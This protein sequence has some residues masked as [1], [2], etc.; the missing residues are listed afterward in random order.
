MLLAFRGTGS[1]AEDFSRSPPS[2]KSYLH[3][4]ELLLGIA[5]LLFFFLNLLLL[6]VLSFF[7]FDSLLLQ[8]TCQSESLRVSF[9]SA[10]PN[11]IILNF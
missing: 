3:H 6:T 4:T 5:Y 11:G 1:A 8:N 2:L 10:L 9:P 7:L